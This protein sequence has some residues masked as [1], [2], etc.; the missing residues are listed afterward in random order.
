MGKVHGKDAALKVGGVD[1]SDHISSID[2]SFDAAAD[3]DTGMSVADQTFQAGLKKAT[4]SCKG[5]FDAASG[6]TDATIWAARG[7]MTALKVGL[8]GTAANTM[9]YAGSGICTAYKPSA[10]V[11]GVVTFSADFQFSGAITRATTAW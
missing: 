11:N 1:L 5:Q 10:P 4:L 9:N 7:V 2:P 6:S 8:A 3:E